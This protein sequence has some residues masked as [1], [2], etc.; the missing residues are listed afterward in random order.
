MNIFTKQEQIQRQREQTCG[1]QREIERDGLE[2]WDYQVQTIKH[3]MDK[4][5]Y[6]TVQHRQL[7]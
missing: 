2:I 6:P 5:P 3:R 7:Y 4:Q 1:C